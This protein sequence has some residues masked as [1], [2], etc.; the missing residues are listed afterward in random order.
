MG[1]LR[2]KA[3]L[4][5]TCANKAERHPYMAGPGRGSRA[6]SRPTLEGMR[7]SSLSLRTGQEQDPQGWKIPYGQKQESRALVTKDGAQHSPPAAASTMRG[8]L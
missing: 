5:K 2:G 3:G 8:A 6:E 4:R 1:P 7:A